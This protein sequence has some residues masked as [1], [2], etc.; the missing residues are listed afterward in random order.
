MH[1]VSIYASLWSAILQQIIPSIDRWAF[2]GLHPSTSSLNYPYQPRP[3]PES[4]E[5]WQHALHSTFLAS[6]R[7]NNY[8][9]MA[10]RLPPLVPSQ[11]PP[12]PITYQEA[13]NSLPYSIPIDNT[14]ELARHIWE[15]KTL[16]AWC[17][18]RVKE[19]KGAH[20]YTVRTP[21]DNNDLCIKGSAITP[22]HPETLRSLRPEHFGGAFAI[23]IH[24]EVTCDFH[25]ILL[26]SNAYVVIHIDSSSPTVTDRHTR[27]HA[28]N[29][30]S[31]PWLRRVVWDHGNSPPSA[32][33]CSNRTC[34][35]PYSQFR[36]RGPLPRKAHYNEQCDEWAAECRDANDHQYTTHVFPASRVALAI[37]NN[38]ITTAPHQAVTLAAT[39]P[40]LQ[41][42]ILNKANWTTSIF[43]SVDLDSHER[44]LNSLSH[45]KNT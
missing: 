12:P 31:M 19:A 21:D 39:T 9:P 37:S 13:L 4:W 35:R 17:D 25:D 27:Q 3:P 30:P 14:S 26:S 8:Q 36:V 18:G 34:Q 33:H 40:K 2:R 15:G 44:Y 43:H 11:T 42:Y 28:S 38:V 7:T 24:L 6:N 20:S 5:I 1:A 16:G 32:H 45:V 23:A 29:I 10:T 22:G 41:T